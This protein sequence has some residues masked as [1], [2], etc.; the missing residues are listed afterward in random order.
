MSEF[1]IRRRI[2]F[3]DTDGGGVVYHTNYLKYMEQARSEMLIQ[4]GFGPKYLDDELD[5]VFAVT[6]LTARYRAPARLGDL[7]EVTATVQDVKSIV[8]TFT[9]IAYSLNEDNE[10]DRELVQA[11]V[12]VVCL[13]S[14]TFKPAR[15]PAILEESVLK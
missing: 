14:K 9:Q 3:D 2:Y 4:Q 6:D 5:T 8:V 15:I 10:R 1:S 11:E 12:K 7:I 13:N